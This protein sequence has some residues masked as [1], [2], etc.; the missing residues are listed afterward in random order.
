MNTNITY[1]NWDLAANFRGQL[2]GQIYNQN[3]VDRGSIIAAAPPSQQSVL[4]NVLNFYN[5]SANPDINQFIGEIAQ[6]DYFLEDATFLR[7]DNISLGYKFLKFVGKSS[8]RVSGT[9][10]NAF[11]ITNYSGQDP[12]SN[13]GRDGSL[14]PRPRT[15]TFGVSLDF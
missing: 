12:E 6:S 14:Y 13:S 1:K 9:V 4:N 3:V 7:C 5:G 8:L 15:Y 10:N 11:L 2:G